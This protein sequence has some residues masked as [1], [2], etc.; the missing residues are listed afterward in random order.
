MY[1]HL[2]WT[3]VWVNLSD[4]APK[5]IRRIHD[6]CYADWAGENNFKQKGGEKYVEDS[7]SLN[8]T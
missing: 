7:D 4:S 8:L 3:A 2:V 1:E 5:W 6:V